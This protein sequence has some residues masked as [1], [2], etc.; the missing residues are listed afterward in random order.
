MR[1]EQSTFLRDEAKNFPYFNEM[2][3]EKVNIVGLFS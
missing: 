1:R 3:F 2:H